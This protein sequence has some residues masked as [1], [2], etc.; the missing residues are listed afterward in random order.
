M[1][2]NT[3]NKNLRVKKPRFGIAEWFGKPFISQSPIERR[4]FAQVSLSETGNKTLP[5]P[6][7]G[8]LITDVRCSKT[9]GVCSIRRYAQ[10]ENGAVSIAPGPVVTVC[11]WRF[12]E[13]ANILR[14]VGK[15]ILGTDRPIVVK[16][17]PFLEKLK[18]DRGTGSE[19]EAES[20]DDDEVR[21]AGRIDWI[22]VNP[23]SADLRWCALETQAVYFSG[24]KMHREFK[25]YKSVKDNKI[26]FPEEV[27]RP[28]YRS[29]GPKRLAPQLS[30]KVPE[31]R[32][33]GRKTA[34]V[35]DRYFFENMSNLPEVAVRGRNEQDMLDAAEVVWFV[36]DYDEATGQLKPLKHLY[37]KLDESV[38]ALNA[39][40]PIGKNTFEDD[41]R[42][43]L[44]SEDKLGSKV[45][46]LG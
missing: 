7:L 44:A 28:D 39:T 25:A 27:R 30:V 35:I 15:V 20:E 17:V 1:K 5:C 43:L 10:A 4:K 38:K 45:F 8:A 41:L 22:L 29:S 46:R 9:G 14:W 36:L 33:W 40:R 19:T 34:I 12:L 6:F 42:K 31:L 26:I 18:T 11:P 32:N 21:K 13:G 16:E 2:K 37:T 23:D 24:K 3:A